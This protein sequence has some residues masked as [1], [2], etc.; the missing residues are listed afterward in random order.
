M[1]HIGEALSSQETGFKASNKSHEIHSEVR[2]IKLRSS[3]VDRDC[4]NTP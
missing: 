3:G 2:Y 4:R 1:A